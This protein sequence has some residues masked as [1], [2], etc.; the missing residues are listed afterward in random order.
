MK[1]IVIFAFVLLFQ[2]V[3]YA[4]S[5]YPVRGMSMQEVIQQQGEPETRKGAVGSP[6]ISRWIYKD[7][8][9]YFEDGTVIH[10]VKNQKKSIYLN[11]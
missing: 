7:F 1:K 2:T 10:S 11:K 6:P 3:S 8:S 5:H 4:D 9:V